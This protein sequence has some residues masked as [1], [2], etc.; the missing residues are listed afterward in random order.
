MTDAEVVLMSGVMVS[1]CRQLRSPTNHLLL[2][3]AVSD[4]LV[5]LLVLPVE[6]LL[7]GTCWVLGDLVCALYFF[8]P[9]TLISASVGNMV[10]I[11]VDRYVAVCDPLHYPTRITPRLVSVCVCVCWICS[12]LYSVFLLLDHLQQPGR[13]NSCSGECV[14]SIAGDVDLVVAFIIP[15]S[16]IVVLY[17]R[18]FVVAVTQ[19][20]SARSQ[21]SVT[22]KVRRSELKA[23]RT[24]GVV[25][26]VFLICYSPYYCLSLTGGNILIGSS[27][28]A[29]M[30]F[31]MYFN[32]CLNPLIY[33]LLYPWFRRAIRLIVTLQILQPDSCETSML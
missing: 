32:S 5:V 6:V 4:L 23:A 1:P 28:E 3:L 24:L 29:A 33:A 17:I 7:T 12:L 22:V 20:R 8:L 18:V 25:V 16:V 13:Y 19:A 31:L 15:I 2:S 27:A 14:V 10:L 9:V 11:S 26:A 21:L 30:S